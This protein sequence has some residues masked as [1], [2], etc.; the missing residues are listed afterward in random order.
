MG[1]LPSVSW[2]LRF[3]C[4]KVPV[5][6]D[7]VGAYGTYL[8]CFAQGKT[9]R[10]PRRASD[11]ERRYYG[12]SI[13]SQGASS[14]E[15]E[16]QGWLEMDCEC[17]RHQLGLARGAPRFTCVD[18]ISSDAFQKSKVTRAFDIAIPMIL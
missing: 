4:W 10:A 18:T 15:F 1:V 5:R 3:V 11:L 12:E 2:R 16:Q 13:F 6:S 17:L 9:V 7:F 8:R 14:V